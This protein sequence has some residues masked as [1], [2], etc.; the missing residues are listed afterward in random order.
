MSDEH[1]LAGGNASGRVVRIGD[2]VRKA[3][4]ENAPAVHGYLTALRSEGVDALRPLGRDDTG[5]QTL[6]YVPGRLAI[7]E[8][9]LDSDAL[10]RVGRM[11][12]AIHDA[13]ERI[14]LPDA[15]S[16]DTL[17]PSPGAPDLVC[18]NDLAPWNLVIGDRWVF[19]DWDGA[20]PSTRIW[21]LAYSAQSFC[22]LVD[23]TPVAETAARLR[24][25]VD[26]Y[27]A[28]ATLRA[29]LPTA[30]AQRTAAMH[31][32]LRT[33]AESGREPW[34]T[35]FAEGHGTFWRDTAAYVAGHRAAWADALTAP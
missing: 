5:R 23:G 2:S 4:T 28:D 35:M 25:F 26:G 12:R 34:A 20:G 11:V 17:L 30:M 24:H 14:A 3:W 16:W 15:G 29:Q 31:E 33:S 22:S 8:L 7:D 21:D 13:S 27:G 9:P 19:I 10:R 32:L 6:E 18:H 1:E